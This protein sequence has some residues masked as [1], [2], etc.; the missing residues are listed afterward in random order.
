MWLDSGIAINPDFIRLSREIYQA[1][2][3]SVNFAHD[4]NGAAEVINQW[5]SH[6]TRGHIQKI[7]SSLDPAIAHILTNAVY[8]AGKWAWPFDKRDTAPN[9][10]Q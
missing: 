4:P 3:R 6:K 1:E 10:F 5:V 2:V 8:F 7:V 9:P